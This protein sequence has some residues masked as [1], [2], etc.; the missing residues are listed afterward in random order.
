MICSN[1]M[2]KILCFNHTELSKQECSKVRTEGKE[3]PQGLTKGHKAE[4]TLHPD[5]VYRTITTCLHVQNTLWCMHTWTDPVWPNNDQNPFFWVPRTVCS[6]E[7]TLNGYLPNKLYNDWK[8]S[9]GWSKKR[10]GDRNLRRSSLGI[11]VKGILI[12]TTLLLTPLCL[13]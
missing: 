11:C 6:L 13:L 4:T 10:V 5:N 8:E 12:P 9:E 3:V 2:P 1:H 7:K